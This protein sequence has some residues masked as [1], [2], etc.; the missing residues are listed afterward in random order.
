MRSGAAKTTFMT[1]AFAM[2]AGCASI[3]PLNSP[4]QVH[5]LAIA[6]NA[7]CVKAGGNVVPPARKGSEAA[8]A[9]E[10]NTADMFVHA[11]FVF[12]ETPRSAEQI[13]R[14]HGA[15]SQICKAKDGN[16]TL[17]YRLVGTRLV[18]VPDRKATCRIG[19]TWLGQAQLAEKGM[20]TLNAGVQRRPRGAN[21][22]GS[23]YL[24]D[25]DA[26]LQLTLTN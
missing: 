19:D 13:E 24:K 5:H 23:V 9:K 11:A 2:L 4:D 20:V 15:L 17:P 25:L 12:V 3:N 10:G 7:S 8:C 21:N 22:E 16:Y 14:A 18:S 1:C 6:F 26:A